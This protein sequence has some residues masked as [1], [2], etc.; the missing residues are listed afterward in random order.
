M[1][2]LSLAVGGLALA[3]LSSPVTAQWSQA[4]PAT[5]PGARSGAAMTFDANLGKI[6]LFGGTAGF[7]TSN[8]TWS[9]DGTTWAQLAP[10]AS[11]TGK[12]GM[13]LVHDL[14]R[15]VTVMYGS[16]NTSLRLVARRS[17]R[18]GNSTAPR[19]RRCSRS[20]PR[21]ALATT[22][23]ALTSCATAP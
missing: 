14:V 7:S 19:G 4:T 18:P 23:P 12:T 13:E 16:L 15:G 10:T 1:K 6:V 22:A 11:P 17:T 2:T 20:R 5:S 21:A 9:F 3:A 8:E